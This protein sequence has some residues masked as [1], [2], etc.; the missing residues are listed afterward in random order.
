MASPGAPVGSGKASVAHTAVDETSVDGAFKRKESV[1]RNFI[2]EDGSSG[3][4]AVA[5]R[6][7][8]YIS[9]ACPWACR[10][11]AFI[12]LKGLEDVIGLSVVK[13]KWEKTREGDSHMGWVFATSDNEEPG[14]TVDPLYGVKSIRDLY[15]LADAD[16]SLGKFSV[17]VLWDKE[18]KT[19]VNNES[20]EII[21]MFN[22]E[23]DK[24]S[25]KHADRDL[26]PPHLKASIDEINEWVYSDINNGV[27]RCGFATKQT[28]YEEAFEKL[29]NALDRCEEILSKQRYLTGNTLTEADIRLFVTLIRFDAVYVVHFK[30]NK[31]LIR[32][33][34][35]LFNYSKDIYQVPGMAKTV[36]MYHIKKHYFMSHP[37]INPHGIIA[38]GMDIDYLAPHDR[39]RFGKL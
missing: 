32:E 36:D 28:P 27:Y 19:I 38:R 29:F 17:P 34:P 21:K 39:E 8:L 30:T 4:P 14:A 24:L 20:S 11:Y 16:Y 37:S 18:R 6:Y 35:N 9:L 25:A 5:G 33:Y 12:V 7:H 26:M 3:F 22:S 23:F 1:F 2:T 10:C 15:D 31:K 13:P